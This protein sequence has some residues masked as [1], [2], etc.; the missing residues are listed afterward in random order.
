MALN[1]LPLHG[2]NISTNISTDGVNIIIYKYFGCWWDKQVMMTTCSEVMWCKKCSVKLPWEPF[3][4]Y[5]WR[6]T[7]SRVMGLHELFL[8]TL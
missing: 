5:L 1:A 7:P 3:P 2:I 6:I 4:L 8:I